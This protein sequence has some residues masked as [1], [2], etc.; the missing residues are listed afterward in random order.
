VV[1]GGRRCGAAELELVRRGGW[2][3]R[4]LGFLGVDWPKSTNWCDGVDG[5]TLGRYA[6]QPGRHAALRALGLPP[7][8]NGLVMP[9]GPNPPSP[10]LPPPLCRLAA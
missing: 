7:T 6:L 10:S 4:V 2:G 5:C 1:V 9:H 3:F 8:P